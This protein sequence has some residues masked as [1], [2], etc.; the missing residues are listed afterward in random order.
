MLIWARWGDRFGAREGGLLSGPG[1]E[2]SIILWEL[3]ENMLEEE[4]DGCREVENT[5]HTR[6]DEG[7]RY[8]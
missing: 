4:E 2:T 6:S 5:F 8:L 1:R 3:W 7:R